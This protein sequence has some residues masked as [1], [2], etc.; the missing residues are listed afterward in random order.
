MDEWWSQR[1]AMD[2]KDERRLEYLTSSERGNTQ[3]GYNRFT[4]KI[5]IE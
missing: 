5:D 1:S 3:V 4:K 2:E